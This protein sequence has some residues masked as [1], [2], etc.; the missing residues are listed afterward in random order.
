MDYEMVAVTVILTVVWWGE[1]SEM[2][3]KP[4]VGWLD[5][6]TAVEMEYAQVASKAD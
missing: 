3:V 1:P 2:L 4:S 6:D 5:T